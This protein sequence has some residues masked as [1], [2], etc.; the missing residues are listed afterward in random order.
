MAAERVIASLA[1][2]ILN[3]ERFTE[4]IE[5]E[6]HD[7]IEAQKYIDTLVDQPNIEKSSRIAGIHAR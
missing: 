1:G 7:F 6:T 2:R 3:L 4:V 5:S